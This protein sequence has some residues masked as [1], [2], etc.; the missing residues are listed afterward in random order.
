MMV[1]FATWKR[2][3]SN[4]GAG[5]RFDIAQAGSIASSD[6]LSRLKPAFMRSLGAVFELDAVAGRLCPVLLAN[7]SVA[8]FA[9]AE[10]VGSDQADELGRRI[11]QHGYALASPQRYVLAAPLLLAIARGQVTQQSLAGQVAA[12]AFQSRTAL[13]DAFQDMVEWGVRNHASDLHLNVRLNEPESEVRYTLAGRYIAPERFGRMPTRML[14]DILSVAWMDIQGGNGAVF[15]PLAEQQGSMARCVDGKQIMLRWASLAA[16]RG[17]SVCLRLLDR[18]AS[19]QRKTLADLGYLPAQIQLIHRAM[20]SEGGAVV[21]AGTVGSGKSTTLAALITALPDHRKV[22]TIEDPV[23]YLI[24]DAIQNTVARSLDIAAHESYAAKLR[25][26]KR[27]AMTDVLLGEIRDQETGRAFMDLASSG[28]NI[29]TTT[30]APSAA[31]IPDRLASDFIGVSRDFLATPGMLKLLVFQALL[32]SLCDCALPIERL[33]SG[34]RAADSQHRNGTQWR[35]WAEM[36]QT[37]YRCDASA[38]RIRNPAGCDACR[39]PQLVALNGYAGRTVVAECIEPALA[40]G[41]LQSIRR[42][43]GYSAAW[44]YGGPCGTRRPQAEELNAADPGSAMN[45]AMHKAL[46]G[47][48]DP[49][50]IESRFQSFETL[51]MQQELLER[52]NRRAAI[53]LPPGPQLRV[54][55]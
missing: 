9:L 38:L 22:V 10:H 47:Q 4:D 31:L 39:R 26:L 51:R 13:A 11:V 24:P 52:G 45:C 8:I 44:P 42:G 37:L 53:A 2:F 34:A 32:P 27:S 33:F 20:L 48:I 5:A 17:P 16:D 7:G 30:H 54:V 28:V 12:P 29:Y 18:D 23:E 35:A 25:A 6:E 40:P 1:R 36:L 19:R 55:P 41:F 21:F 15:D 43:A 49:R 3:P 50:D 46:T 14:V